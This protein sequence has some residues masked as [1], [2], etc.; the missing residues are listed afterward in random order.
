M[1]IHRS[2][3]RHSLVTHRATTENIFTQVGFN[4][5]GCVNLQR[6]YQ[7]TCHELNVLFDGLFQANILQVSPVNC[8]GGGGGGGG[9]PWPFNLK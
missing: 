6:I 2:A 9:G 7:D 8:R 3:A 4:C 1:T 5:R